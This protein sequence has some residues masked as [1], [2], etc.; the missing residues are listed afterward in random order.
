MAV[1]Q[2]DFFQKAKYLKTNIDTLDDYIKSI[3][4]HELRF[5]PNKPNY[6]TERFARDITRFNTS[7]LKQYEICLNCARDLSLMTQKMIKETSQITPN[8][9]KPQLPTKEEIQI[10]M[11]D[12][13]TSKIRLRVSPIP[14]F[15]GCYSCRDKNR[16]KEGNFICARIDENYILMIVLYYDKENKI[17][18]AYDPADVDHDKINVVK[19]Q[20]DDWTPLPT[21]I[22][23][24]PIKRWEHAKDSTVLSLWPI[25]D[26]TWTSV[27]YKATVKLQPCERA[28]NEERGY[29]LDFGDNQIHIVPEKFVVTFPDNWQT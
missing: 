23:E 21:D 16:L 1:N 17:C 25:Q 10:L 18:S 8:L 2:N 12:F 6:Q 24:K 20:Y 11:H 13:Y 4:A 29:E 22:P 27:F 15:C 26:G 3:A 5:Q 28:D 7:I 9:S 19:L 14:I